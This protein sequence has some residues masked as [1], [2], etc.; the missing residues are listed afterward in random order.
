MTPP[1][2]SKTTYAQ[3][4]QLIFAR[5]GFA[6]PFDM[7]PLLGK[8]SLSC[9]AFLLPRYPVFYVP[10]MTS[11]SAL[12]YT[13]SS[14]TSGAQPNLPSTTD[15]S[16]ERVQQAHFICSPNATNFPSVTPLV[17]QSAPCLLANSRPAMTRASLRYEAKLR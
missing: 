6:D 14:T 10:N 11:H 7:L 12:V 5:R 9:A 1:A 2:R 15:S 3:Q 17:I 13:Q 4:S 16:A 8:S